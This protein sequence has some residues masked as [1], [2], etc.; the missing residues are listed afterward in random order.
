MTKSISKVFVAV[1]GGVD[2]SVALALL[3]RQ[4]Y[5]I[6][7]CF[8]KNWSRNLPG[9][10]CNWVGD[11][12][13]AIRVCAKLGVPFRE[14]DLEKTYY[15]KVFK[16]FIR[17]YKAG[18]TPNPDIL[19]NS[20][21]KFK[22]FLQ[23]AL[24]NGA[25]MI[26]TGH[27][28]KIQNSKIKNQNDKSKFKIR[29]KLA[30][31]KDKNK[32]QSYFLYRLGQKELSRTLFPIGEYDK[33]KVRMLARK[34]GL[35][36]ADKPDSQGVCFVGEVSLETFLQNF[37]PQK[38]GRIIRLPEKGYSNVRKNI[39]IRTSLVIGEHP[40]VWYFTIGQRHHLG[41]KGGGKVLY[42]AAKDVKRNILYVAP[43]NHPALYKKE[44]LLKDVSW[45]S[46]SALRLPFRC[47]ARIRYRQPLQSCRIR[48]AKNKKQ[49][50]TFKVV[51]ENPQWAPASGQS[52]VF[53]KD[54]KVIGGGVIF[55][56]HAR[57]W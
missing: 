13:D 32:D 44:L 18:R 4:G 15:E 50:A 25:D 19:C 22:A 14:V 51:F 45:V 8:M 34:F 41:V 42:V 33:P 24:K 31:A 12:K 9:L 56:Q 54:E 46:G 10:E 3:K 11:K 47:M 53:Y 30:V 16:N 52:A 57:S 6:V 20:E 5:D 36:T 43:K 23:W 17:E 48:E 28:A 35:P 2:S 49:K 1:S 21:V 40:G 7:G 38:L 27:Y 37:I 26:A 29:Y 55:T 39:G